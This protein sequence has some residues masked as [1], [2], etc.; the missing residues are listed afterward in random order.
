VQAFRQLR[1]RDPER[2]R[3]WRLVLVGGSAG[4]SEYLERLRVEAKL[5]RAIELHVN[6]P[7]DQVN[8]FYRRASLFWH[9]CG[10]DEFLPERVEHFGMATVEAMQQGCIPIVFDGGGQREI[11]VDGVSGYRVATIEELIDR[12]LKLIGNPIQRHA[13]IQRVRDRGQ[14]FNLGQFTDR[15]NT[16]FDAISREF[17]TIALPNPG[18]IYQECKT[19]S[20]AE[21]QA[22]L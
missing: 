13:M 15:V 22:D 5:D 21:I 14:C 2:L 10:F 9:L 7:L 6:L 16:L 3:D 11:V 20:I 17:T 12:T 19:L 18:E 1:D 4:E 8:G